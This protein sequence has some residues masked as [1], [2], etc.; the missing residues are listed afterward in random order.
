M[1]IGRERTFGRPVVGSRRE[2]VRDEDEARPGQRRRGGKGGV[3]AGEGGYKE[4]MRARRGW[5]SGHEGAPGGVGGETEK[6]AVQRVGSLSETL[7]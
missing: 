3:R 4:G 6:E 2:E 7:V 1:R 5:P